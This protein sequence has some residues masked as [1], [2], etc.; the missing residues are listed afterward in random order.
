MGRLGG[1]NMNDKYIIEE[2]AVL[3]CTRNPQAH[4]TEECINCEFKNGMCDAYSHTKKILEYL[5]KDSV[6]LTMEEKNAL[7]FEAWNKATEQTRKET[8]KEILL[9]LKPL[10][11]GFVHTDTGENLYIYKCKQF[12]M[13]VG[14]ER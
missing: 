8:I 13:E 6:V 9:D 11:E 1:N 5:F 4:T 3:G 2:L 12:G 14:K 7:W 10:L